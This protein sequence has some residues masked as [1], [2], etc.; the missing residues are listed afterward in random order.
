M[1]E[2]NKP[3]AALVLALPLMAMAADTVTLSPGLWEQTV[4]TTALTIGGE[5]RSLDE[6]PERTRTFTTCISEAEAADPTLFFMSRAGGGS[7]GAP[8]GTVADGKLALAA[9]C[10]GDTGTAIVE[11][12]GNY[13]AHSFSAKVKAQ[14]TIAG[15]PAVAEI[16]LTGEH[17]GLCPVEEAPAD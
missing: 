6:M 9:T 13:S 7:C 3:I 5:P 1:R 8:T 11:L 12:Q 14:S 4:T 2:R 16:T 17:K 15:A 10:D